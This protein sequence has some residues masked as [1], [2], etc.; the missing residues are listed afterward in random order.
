MN[1]LDELLKL[2][3]YLDSLNVPAHE[4]KE[5][6]LSILRTYIENRIRD[7]GSHDEVKL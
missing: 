7:I 2:S 5:N 3:D 4:M 6:G 1:R